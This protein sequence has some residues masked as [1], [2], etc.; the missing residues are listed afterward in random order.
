MDYGSVFF[1]LVIYGGKIGLNLEI[2]ISVI[3][4]SL[5]MYFKTYNV[6]QSI[7]DTPFVVYGVNIHVQGVGY[8]E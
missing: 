3:C 2:K 8:Y 5:V 1:F 6:I 7:H 4:S